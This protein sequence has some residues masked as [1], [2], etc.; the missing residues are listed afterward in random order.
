MLVSG[1][2]R[3]VLWAPDIRFFTIAFAASLVYAL[4]WY[5]PGFRVLYALLPGVSLYRRPAD[6]VFLIGGL[7]A[8]VAGYVVHRYLATPL[9]ERRLPYG[10]IEIGALAAAFMVCGV[11]AV[12]YGRGAQSLAPLALAVGSLCASLAAIAAVEWLEPIRPVA[13]L[14][15][16]AVVSAADL[17]INNGPNGASGLP[18]AQFDMLEPATRN[19]TVA[20][21]RRKVA[22][23]AGDT[24]RDRVELVGLGFN[25]P[26]ASLTHGLENTL[27]YNPVRLGIYSRATG[28]EDH[29]GL[30][31][32]RKFSALFPSYKSKLAD[33]LGLRWIASGVPI[34]EIDKRLAPGALPLIAR[35]AD[36]YIYENPSALPRVLFAGQAQIGD[37]ERI[38]STGVWPDVDLANTVILESGS[39]DK[40]RQP[41]R[42]RLASYRNTEVVIEADSP[43]GGW[44]VLN[45][46]WHPWWRAT[47]DGQSRPVQ[48][49]NVLFRAVEVPPGRHAVVF[50]FR[51]SA[52]AVDEIWQGHQRRV[53]PP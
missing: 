53:A 21:L 30:P 13:A 36:G 38:L 16:L 37:F 18:P 24:R 41:G 34:A 47:V 6:A 52:G 14:G 22:E 25:W 51:P 39:P 32:Q 43:D 48:R 45:D 7:G 11:V 12:T 8:I 9:H 29:S 3:G 42:V 23:S 19:E 40:Q 1:A 5:T 33:L 2:V 10:A 28:A 27:G 35:T 4:G 46:V 15:L 44:V 50:T 49:A 31:D 20:L 17:A 26:N